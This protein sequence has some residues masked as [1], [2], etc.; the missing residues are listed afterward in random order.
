[1]FREAF[2]KK[3]VLRMFW[4]P[5]NQKKTKYYDKDVGKK[6]RTKHINQVNTGKMAIFERL[7]LEFSL[8]PKLTSIPL[9]VFIF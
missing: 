7:L 6:I 9:M 1:M 4:L 5:K 8:H 2:F 3:V